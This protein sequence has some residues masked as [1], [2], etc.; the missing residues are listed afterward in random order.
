MDE[1][2]KKLKDIIVRLATRLEETEKNLNKL[3]KA[4]SKTCEDVL[5]ILRD[6]EHY[7]RTT[8]TTELKK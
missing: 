1:E 2:V 5:A 8:D 6:G 4:C 7:H 3:Q